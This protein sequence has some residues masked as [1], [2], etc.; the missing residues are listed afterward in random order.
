M[1]EIAWIKI[2]DY[3]APEEERAEEFVFYLKVL[4]T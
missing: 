4:D 3:G 1:R 2:F